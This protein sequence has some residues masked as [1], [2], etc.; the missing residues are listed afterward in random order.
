MASTSEFILV[1]RLG[2]TRGVQ[3]QLWITP[4]TDFP[5]RF[6]DLKEIH[7]S[8]RGAWEK[9]A[10]ELTQIVSDR[11]LIKFVGIDTREDAARLTNRD[12]AVKSDQLVELPPDMHYVF[13]LIGCEV[14]ELNTERRLGEI[15]DV[16]KYPANDVYLVRTDSGREILYPAVADFVAEIDIEARKVVV[17]DTGLFDEADKKTE[18]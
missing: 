15:T 8:D 2:R 3:G 9:M 5:D 6:L 17:R 10:I 14:V 11:P 13:E 12:L 4:L 7:V 18:K 1:G 16:K